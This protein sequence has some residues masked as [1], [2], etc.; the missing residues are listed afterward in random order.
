MQHKDCTKTRRTQAG[1]VKCRS[2]R[3]TPGR[4]AWRKSDARSVAVARGDVARQRLAFLHVAADGF[5]RRGGA[6]RVGAAEGPVAAIETGD[7]AGAPFRVRD[8]PTRSAFPSPRA[9]GRLSRRTDCAG[10]AASQAPPPAASARAR[11]APRRLAPAASRRAMLAARHMARNRDV[12]RISPCGETIC[13]SQGDF[14]V[15]SRRFG[16]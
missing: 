9:T 8:F 16:A 13:R 11:T 15:T 10:N 5:R 3:A 2:W 12:R 6:L 4:Q 14:R 7:E 1:S